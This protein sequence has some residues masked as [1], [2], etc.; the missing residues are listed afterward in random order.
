MGDALACEFLGHHWSR[1][2]CYGDV[3]NA[4]RAAVGDRPEPRSKCDCGRFVSSC[5][6]CSKSVPNLVTH[7]CTNWYFSVVLEISSR[8]TLKMRQTL[9]GQL[10]DAYRVVSK[11]TG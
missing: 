9:G 8:S 7:L 4:I 5:I 3:V 6:T 2:V 11:S 1:L 10:L